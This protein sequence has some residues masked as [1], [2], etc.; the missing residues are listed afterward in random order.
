MTKSEVAK[1]YLG[2]LQN[3]DVEAVISLFTSDGIVVSPVY[4]TKVASVFYHELNNDTS[5]SQLDLKGIFEETDSNNIALYFTYNW[6]L[7]NNE[8]VTFDVVDIIELNSKNN[9][10]K[11]TII[12]DT[13][14]SRRLVKELRS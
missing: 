5:Q 14:I 11:L 8:K 4:G 9:I 6:T 10:Q 12:Y 13:V 1:A 2:Y 3:G 7:Q